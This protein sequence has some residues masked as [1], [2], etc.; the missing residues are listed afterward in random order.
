MIATIHP[1][2]TKGKVK[3][4]PSKS[5]SHRAII[6]AALAK[7][8]SRIENVA[9]SKDIL[10]T[11]EGM[12]ALGATIITHDDFVEIEGIQDFHHLKYNT[13]DCGE[14]GSTLRF[15]IPIF[16]LCEEIIQ[17][18]GSQRLMERPQKAYQDI[19]ANRGLSFIQED[20]K[21]E[22]S[23]AL[24]SGEYIL[25]GNVSS[26]FISGLLFI[27]PLLEG[28]STIHIKPPFESRSY[29]DLTL[30]MLAYFGVH[31]H[32][33]DEHTIDIPGKQ[34]YHN[35]CYSIEG[36]YSQLAFFAVLA[37]LNSDLKITGVN[38]DSLQGDKE[39]I[40]ILR[41]AGVKIEEILQGYHVFKSDVKGSKIDLANCPDLGPIL[42]TLGAYA[43]G[44]THIYNAQRLRIKESDRIE[45]MQKELTTLGASLQC[46]EGDIYIQGAPQYPGGC[47]F[48]GHNDHRIVMSIAVAS[49]ICEQANTIDEA[50][51]IQ[52]SYPQF[53]DDLRICGIEVEEDEER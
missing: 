3:I 50:Q 16:S 29:V 47:K 10:I 42:C 31:A 30:Q 23:G 15:F 33:T 25:D 1:G 14:S 20:G 12:R 6:C 18:N 51:A 46:E 38:H 11:I 13:I 9:Y 5:M 48:H 21:I 53:F 2:I 39:I 37:A 49:T 19:F 40:E 26:Q 22:I 27:L 45:A 4:P 44:E 7:G 43:N 52:K 28:H 34:S 36:D 32:F 8:K 35:V 17:F 41:N 24:S